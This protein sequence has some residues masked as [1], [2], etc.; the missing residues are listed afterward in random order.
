MDSASQDL[1]RLSFFTSNYFIVL[2]YIKA[3]FSLFN[4]Q[5]IVFSVYQSLVNLFVLYRKKYLKFK[6]QTEN[7]GFIFE[8]FNYACI[9]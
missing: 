5:K 2:I 7:A 1:T 4:L 6:P 8:Q 3:K 9:I